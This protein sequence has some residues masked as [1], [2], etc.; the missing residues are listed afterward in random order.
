MAKSSYWREKNKEIVLK[1][2][3]SSKAFA[4]IKIGNADSFKA[5]Y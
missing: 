2:Q 1:L 3:T 5:I 4:L